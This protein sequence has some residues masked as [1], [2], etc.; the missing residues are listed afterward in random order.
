MN[1]S[2]MIA[3]RRERLEIGIYES[4]EVTVCASGMS[5]EEGMKM[6]LF[7]LPPPLPSPSPL[8]IVRRQSVCRSSVREES[9]A[10]ASSRNHLR[11]VACLR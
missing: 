11:G 1:N 8:R 5:F 7:F 6:S 9:S 10:T 4:V 2:K 3:I